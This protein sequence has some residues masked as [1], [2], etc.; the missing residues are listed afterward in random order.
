MHKQSNFSFVKNLESQAQPVETLLDQY[1]SGLDP[2]KERLY[3]A[4]FKIGRLDV[5]QK[6]WMEL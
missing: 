5:A 2:T 3:E 4:L 6:I 1:V